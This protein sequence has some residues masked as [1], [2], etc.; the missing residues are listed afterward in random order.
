MQSLRIIAMLIL[1]CSYG[2]AEGKTPYT[3][4][5][6]AS[7]KKLKAAGR[8]SK[9]SNFEK[10]AAVV[11]SGRAYGLGAF[12]AR[13][14]TRKNVTWSST[15]SRNGVDSIDTNEPTLLQGEVSVGG[16][17]KRSRNVF[18]ASAS[19]I[20]GVAKFEF[21][22]KVRGTR[23]SRQ[24]MYT[25]TWDV[26][27]SDLSKARVSSLP[28]SVFAKRA[29]QT[30]GHEHN[31]EHQHAGTIQQAAIQAAPSTESYRVVTISTDADPEWYARYGAQ[32]NAEIASII[33]TAEAMYERQLGIHL[34]IVKQH[35]YTDYAT[36]PYTANVASEL[37][38][39]FSKNPENPSNLGNGVGVF[40]QE[41]DLK[42]LFTGKELYKD[43]SRIGTTTGIAYTSAF[44]W[45][46]K[47]AYAVTKSSML[48]SVTFAHEVGHN[49]GASHDAS[50]PS[51]VMYTFIRP[52]SSLSSTS[53]QQINS[54]LEHFGAC[55]SNEELA[56]NLHN[57]KLS[58]KKKIINKGQII[59][60]QGV[61]LSSTGSPVGGTT[62]RIFINSKVIQ[63]KTN[64]N[65]VYTY[66]LKVAQLKGRGAV[67]YS[68]TQNAEV[69]SA[70]VL[71]IPGKA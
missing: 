1:C 13:F 16:S 40:D 41:V 64:V 23:A 10:V 6:T 30:L 55:L 35:V 49:L 25:I 3:T 12:S 70:Q 48:T 29:C 47:S 63:A 11:V 33:N 56:P 14:N 9:K 39:Q 28:A 42:H 17:W 43:Q 52:N 7:A 71:A 61:L 18:P 15:I 59:K 45:A 53:L 69:Q 66:N 67:V 8:S 27:S 4:T 62:V 65:G 19:V 38:G 34:R 54:H 51:G 20:N 60:I 44:C 2:Y 26:G 46:P 22:G 37:L 57:T 31:G 21:P 68:E 50:D 24:R 5:V 32:S 58:I 36:S